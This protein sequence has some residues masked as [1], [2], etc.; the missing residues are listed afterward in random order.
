LITRR[1]LFCSAVF[2]GASALQAQDQAPTPGGGV[3]AEQLAKANNPLADLN[4]VSLQNFYDPTLYGVSNVNANTLDLRGVIVSGRQ[5]IR[6]T[7]PIVADPTGRESIDV[8]GAGSLP[9]SIPIGPVQYRSGLGDSS[10]FD[11]IRLTSD[12]AK[13]ALA[14]GPM[15]VA[16]TATNSALGDGK[17][18]LGVAGVV[19]HPLSGGSLIGALIT[20]QHD[21][22]GDKD[23]P[24]TNLGSIQPFLSFGIG[25]GFY[26]KSGATWVLDFQ[27]NAYLIP[28]GLGVGKVFRVG[29][30]LANASIEPQFSVYHK[31]LGLPA[32]QLVAGLSF[33]W[34]KKS[35]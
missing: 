10:I 24:G 14:V 9:V 3:T 12:T 27:N 34:A 5:I 22:A 20:Y 31:G 6:L 7:V 15:L 4:S 16:P 19:V 11:S 28:I 33:Q 35:K 25:A 26:V 21:V 1:V 29:E 30:T 17:W 18:Q 32:F 13:T 8:P 23:R 2:L